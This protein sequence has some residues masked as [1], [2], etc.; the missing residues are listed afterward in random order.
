MVQLGIRVVQLGIAW[1]NLEFAWY[2]LE[3][4][5]YK[6]GTR[7]VQAGTR[8]V[9]VGT[10]GNFKLNLRVTSWNSRSTGWNSRGTGGIGNVTRNLQYHP[11]Q[12]IR[13]SQGRHRVRMPYHG[14]SDIEVF[15][16][17]PA[18]AHGRAG[19]SRRNRLDHPK[20]EPLIPLLPF[21]LRTHRV[22][23]PMP[24][25]NR[26]FNRRMIYIRTRDIQ[27]S[28]QQTKAVGP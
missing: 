18:R 12:A 28:P 16:Q 20:N 5:W 26:P 10:R 9:Q 17:I 8:M 19:I 4:A 22:I 21:N 27:F 24:K 1:Y 15:N 6:V 25:T 7:M 2:K 13:Y 11:V 3:L 23:N 14:S